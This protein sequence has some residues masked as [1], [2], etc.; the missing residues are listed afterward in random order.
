MSS[1][2]F[3]QDFLVRLALLLHAGKLGL[4]VSLVSLSHHSEPQLLSAIHRMPQKL[5]PQDALGVSG[6]LPRPTHPVTPSL[7]VAQQRTQDCSSDRSALLPWTL[8]VPEESPPGFPFHWVWHEINY[9]GSQGK[10]SC[11]KER[12][13]RLHC[14]EVGTCQE[15]CWASP[16]GCCRIHQ[17]A[18]VLSCLARPSPSYSSGR[19][20]RQLEIFRMID[21]NALA[22]STPRATHLNMALSLL[23]FNRK[24]QLLLKWI[25][26]AKFRDNRLA[27][28]RLCF[29]KQITENLSSCVCTVLLG[30]F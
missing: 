3:D 12:G 26:T 22:A 27:K 23:D 15:R 4:A 14:C 10:R 6:L 7:K 29:L 5:K 18:L 9:S 25:V 1:Q 8:V 30:W 28:T 21:Q 24:K 16:M 2:P 13:P 17:M 11:L 19:G 20:W